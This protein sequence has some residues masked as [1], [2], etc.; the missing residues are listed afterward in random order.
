[1]VPSVEKKIAELEIGLLHLQQNIE[2]PEITLVAHPHVVHVIQ[3]RL[4]QNK[5]AKVSDFEDKN[6]DTQFLN[7]LQA[8]VNRWIKEIQK[9]LLYIQATDLLATLLGNEIEQGCQHW[10]S[11]PGNIVLAESRT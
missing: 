1:M 4:A 3:E 8:G 5:E 6:D 9:V 11:S 7:Q 10:N 2:I